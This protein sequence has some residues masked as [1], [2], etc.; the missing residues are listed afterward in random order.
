MS[1]PI[2]PTEKAECLEP[3]SILPRG[4]DRLLR[5]SAPRRSIRA[6]R[7]DVVAASDPNDLPGYALPPD[8][9]QRLDDFL[10]VTNVVHSV[11]KWGYFFVFAHPLRAHAR[12]F[13]DDDVLKLLVCGEPAPC[14]R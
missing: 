12:Y 6:P 10:H 8:A 13:E 2:G 9:S 11:A 3:P 7:I 1:Q 4:V 5:E 14:P